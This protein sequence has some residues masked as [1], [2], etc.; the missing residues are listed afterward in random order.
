MGLSPNPQRALKAARLLIEWRELVV[1]TSATPA[2]D[3][4]VQALM[5][6]C[7]MGTFRREAC[8]KLDRAVLC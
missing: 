3:G 2:T 7:E 6:R 1:S 5:A 8:A 4:E